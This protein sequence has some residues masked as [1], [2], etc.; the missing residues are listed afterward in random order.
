M[1]DKY[2]DEQKAEIVQ[3]ALLSLSAGQSLRSYCLANNLPYMTVWD[4]LNP[5]GVTVHSP[6]ARAKGAG[7]HYLAD[8]CLDIADE[9]A[10]GYVPAGVDPALAEAT[11]VADI[12]SRVQV[13]KLRIDTRL[14][15][16]GKWNRKDYGDKTAIVGGDA[17]DAPVR[18]VT[19]MQRAKAI[20]SVVRKATDGAAE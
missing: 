4:W 13:A 1:A 17:D 6:Y 2:T 19:D 8:E 15:L 7:S 9:L 14:R 3:G 16:I 5:D 11:G 20:L 12:G 10:K 18:V